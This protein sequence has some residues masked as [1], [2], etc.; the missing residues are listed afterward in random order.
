[1]ELSD[2]E[3]EYC[4]Q[5]IVSLTLCK[6][7]VVLLL[8]CIPL[9]VTLWTAARHAFLSMTNSQ[10][11]LKLMP[12]ESVMSSYH[13][14]LCQ[15]LLLPSVFPSMRVFSNESAL[16]IRWPKYWNFRFS[17]SISLSN[18]YLELI[19]F[20]IHWFY[21]LAVQGTLSRDF[22]N[23]TVQKHQFVGTQPSLCSTSHIQL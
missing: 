21:F 20:K 5:T 2:S 15:P 3:P 18:E 6:I 16:H 13:L 10:S 4:I 14:N 7:I 12:I 1:M 19:S 11:L 22:S 23:T 9:F 17:F 8:S